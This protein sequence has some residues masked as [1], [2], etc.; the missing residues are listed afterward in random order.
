MGQT[1]HMKTLIPIMMAT[2]LG[3]GKIPGLEVTSHQ[4]NQKDVRFV[5]KSSRVYSMVDWPSQVTVSIS[6][7]NLETDVT[8]GAYSDGSCTTPALGN[9]T[10]DQNPVRVVEGVATFSGLKYQTAGLNEEQI[11]LKASTATASECSSDPIAVLLPFAPGKGHV[12]LRPGDFGPSVTGLWG[13][14]VATDES[15]RL[16]I[17]GTISFG[18]FQWSLILVRLLSTGELDRTFGGSGYVIFH[19]NERGAAGA[20]DIDRRDIAG[21]L[22][23]DSDGRYVI[24]GASK[25]AAGG[26]EV[27][28]W[29]YLNDGNL[30]SSFG[31]QGWIT[32]RPGGSGAAGSA[33][34]IKF[35]SPGGAD[36]MHFDQRR[37]IV[38]GGF[39][40]N[41]NGGY[42][43]AVWRFAS[44]G[45]SDETFGD[46]GVVTFENNGFG[47]SGATAANKFDVIYGMQIDPFGRYVMTGFSNTNAQG[48]VV[49]VW[50][51][52]ADGTMDTSF[53]GGK[54]F[55]TISIAENKASV[56]N[57]LEYDNYATGITIDRLGRIGIALNSENSEGGM[58]IGVMRLLPEGQPDLSFGSK[59]GYLILRSLQAGFAGSSSSDKSDNVGAF[60][61]DDA[62]RFVLAGSV[63]NANGTNSLALWRIT[64]S[65]EIDSSF[66]NSGFTILNEEQWSDA[67]VWGNLIQDPQGRYTITG[68]E[69][70]QEEECGLSVMR[71]KENGELDQ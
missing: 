69:I 53:G 29:R 12:S 28:V 31:G 17:A 66:G 18:N 7:T 38:I 55:V 16:I 60:L 41:S 23:I 56:A 10:A 51:M 43:A 11:Y 24:S 65:G 14:S 71:F 46:G 63:T 45:T 58:E 35:D 32:F 59:D 27:V 15:G 25:N 26:F 1:I 5:S 62:E 22:K 13:S 8:L 50:R 36:S 9:L 61:L 52:K 49:P 54:G 37:R 70:D 2:V 47:A 6:K 42:S 64:S 48:S 68:W 39:S 40:R 44:S 67:S 3:C 33:N 4:P 34:N 30:D 20:L 57:P 19:E 21:D